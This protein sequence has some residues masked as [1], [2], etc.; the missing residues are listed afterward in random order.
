MD[1]GS[2]GSQEANNQEAFKGDALNVVGG[3]GNY[4]GF[5]ELHQANLYNRGQN[6]S[7]QL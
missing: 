1:L 7:Q 3:G 2:T 5:M 6:Q 4:S